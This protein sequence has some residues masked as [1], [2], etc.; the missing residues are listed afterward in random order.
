MTDQPD[1]ADLDALAEDLD[2]L[3]A[4]ATD[5]RRMET[6]LDAR[7]AFAAANGASVRDLASAT[8]ISKSA[9]ARRLVADGPLRSTSVADD[10][11]WR[12]QMQAE[13]MKLARLRTAREATR[14]SV[15]QNNAAL[16]EEANS[17]TRVTEIDRARITELDRDR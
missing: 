6:E 10:P 2:A 4:M 9:V 7:L 17:L 11:E 14:L 1:E 13:R 12:E 15:Q 5:A 8:G 3:E 16:I